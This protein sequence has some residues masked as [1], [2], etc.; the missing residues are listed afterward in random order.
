[1]HGIK[2]VILIVLD[3][4]GIGAAPDADRY[5]DG[6]SNT[7]G[8]VAAALEGLNLPHLGALGLGNLTPVIGVPSV[9]K[10]AGAWGRMK[11]AAAGKDTTTGH[12]ELAGLILQN[13]FPVYP[14]GFP[15]EVIIP[16]ERAFGRKVLGN[17]PASGT[18]II[19]ELGEEHLATGRPIVYTSADSVFQVAAHEEVIPP[20]ELYELCLKARRILR[21]KHAVGRVIARPFVGTPGNFRRTANRRD[22]SLEPP[23]ETLLD[24]LV[25]AGHEVVGIGKIE[26]IFA[27][28]GVTRS[29]HTGNNQE[30]MDRTLAVVAEGGSG[31]VFVNLVDF[32]MLFGHRNDPVGYGQALEQFDQWLPVL[33]QKMAASDLL[34]ITGDHGC[35]PTTSSTDHSREYV[36]LLVWGARCRPNAHLGTRETFADV[37]ATVA[38][39]LG[40]G[41]SGPGTSFWPEVINCKEGSNCG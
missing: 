16:I 22:F 38:D 36:P 12:W 27:G 32:D 37:A 3:S 40:A 25:E 33:Q 17:K 41:W 30:G 6:D 19:A 11:P 14:Y 23:Q 9:Q 8:H 28:R 34:I 21:G 7:L 35:D 18:E 15:P 24:R 4:L 2:R 13:P 10:A 20:E 5:G 31:L 26:D 39:I 29:L 1:M